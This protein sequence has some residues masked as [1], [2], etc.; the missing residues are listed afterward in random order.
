LPSACR[1]TSPHVIGSLTSVIISSLSSRKYIL[2]SPG[3]RGTG[4]LRATRRS[5]QEQVRPAQCTSGPGACARPATRTPPAQGPSVQQRREFTPGPSR[6]R[7]CAA[8]AFHILPQ[9]RLRYKKKARKG[10]RARRSRRGAA[11]PAGGAW[12][13]DALGYASASRKLPAPPPRDDVA[14]LGTLNTRLPPSLVAKKSKAKTE[15]ISSS[16][17]PSLQHVF[18]CLRT[19]FVNH[20]IL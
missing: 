6:P 1:V 20:V 13:K 15:A 10:S 17:E 16:N 5:R 2:P 3:P 7:A 9:T 12:T 19:T 14:G 18:C 4:Q 11:P 8:L